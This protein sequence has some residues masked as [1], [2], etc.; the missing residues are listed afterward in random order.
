MFIE[1]SLMKCWEKQMIED[2]KPDEN[3]Y[4]WLYKTL[5]DKWFLY[6]SGPNKKQLYNIK[7]IGRTKMGGLLFIRLNP[8]NKL[9]TEVVVNEMSEFRSMVIINDPDLCKTLDSQYAGRLLLK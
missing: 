3:F 6:A 1:T 9:I 8:K 4:E 2:P 5:L 7:M